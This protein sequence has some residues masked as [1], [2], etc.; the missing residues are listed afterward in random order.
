MESLGKSRNLSLVQISISDRCAL[1]HTSDGPH[2]YF[3]D[4]FKI[5]F[6]N[7]YRQCLG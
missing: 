4:T 1:R 2:V 7:Y 5:I 3:R 6:L